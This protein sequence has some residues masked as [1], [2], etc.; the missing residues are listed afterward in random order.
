MDSRLATN[1]NSE[2]THVKPISIFP[3]AGS[4][5]E[6]PALGQD[7]PVTA[8]FLKG[9]WHKCSLA[10]DRSEIRVTSAGRKTLRGVLNVVQKQAEDRRRHMLIGLGVSAGIGAVSTLVATKA[11]GTCSDGF[12]KLRATLRLAMRPGARSEKSTNAPSPGGTA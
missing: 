12:G 10:R 4:F 3:G 2:K 6:A 9:N 7:R 11:N 8:Q 1:P 5:L